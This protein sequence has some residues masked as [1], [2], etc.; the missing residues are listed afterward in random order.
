MKTL[1]LSILLVL[2]GASSSFA[3]LST[4]I[5]GE[6]SSASLTNTISATQTVEF[7]S[8]S[9]DTG[10]VME[11]IMGDQ[12]MKFGSG[13]GANVPTPFVVAGPATFIFRKTSGGSGSLFTYRIGDKDKFEMRAMIPPPKIQGR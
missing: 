10:T 5:A 4:W 9:F 1:L 13:S 7:I 6:G 3:Q 8:A 11:I 2:S 12:M